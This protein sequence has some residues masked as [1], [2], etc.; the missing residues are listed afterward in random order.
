MLSPLFQL[1]RAGLIYFLLHI[2][3]A[4]QVRLQLYGGPKYDTFMAKVGRAPAENEALVAKQ[5]AHDERVVYW[6]EVTVDGL[7]YV[8]HPTQPE[9][10]CSR[11]PPSHLQAFRL[12]LHPR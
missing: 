9:P 1:R 7:R 10:S 6:Q 2:C 8:A 12:A 5:E 3:V 11:V 4:G